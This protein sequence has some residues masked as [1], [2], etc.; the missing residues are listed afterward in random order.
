MQESPAMAVGVDEAV[1]VHEA[2]V[3][4]FV[5]RRASRSKGLRDEII[6]LLTTLATQRNQHLHRLS[7]IANGLGGEAAELVM[8]R[9]HD[10]DRVTDNDTGRTVARELRIERIAEGLEKGLRPG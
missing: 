10:G 3:L 7:R 6:D 5:V 1:R 8:R 4:R 2:K 9:Q